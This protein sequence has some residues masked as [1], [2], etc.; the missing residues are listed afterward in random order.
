[1]AEDRTEYD[2]GQCARIIAAI[3]DGNAATGGARQVARGVALLG[4]IRLVTGH[5]LILA[6]ER[7]PLGTVCG[8]A[9]YGVGATELVRVASASPRRNARDA[10]RPP[11]RAAA[12]ANAEERRLK[13]LL[14][15]VDLTGGFFF[16]HTYRLTATLQANAFDPNAALR[17]DFDSMFAWNAHLS[18]PLR[19]ALGEDAA[20]RWLVPLVHGFFSQRVVDLVGRRVRIALVARR[21]RHFAGTRYRR[22]GVNEEGHVA[23]EVETEQIVDD[24]GG[25]G[26]GSRRVPAVS[27]VVQTRGSIPLFWTQELSARV[28]RPEIT[29]QRFDPT[30]A[31]TARHFQRL[32]DR[33]GPPTLVLSLV[34][35]QERRAREGAL[36]GELAAALHRVNSRLPEARERVACVHWDFAKHMTRGGGGGGGGGGVKRGDG[37]SGEA[38]NP[39]NPP[40]EPPPP[41]P[42]PFPS[43]APATTPGLLELTR[44]AAGA[45]ELTG[46]FVVAPVAGLR[47]AEKRRATDGRG[48]PVSRATTAWREARCELF[49]GMD[50]VGDD[51]R[52]APLGGGDPD[53]PAPGAGRSA[54]PWKHAVGVITP[55][56]SSAPNVPRASSVGVARQR[57]VLRSHCIDCLDRTNVAQFA[58]GLAS[59]AAQLEALGIGD[60]APVAPDGTLAGVLMRAYRAMGNALALQ[61]GGSEAHAKVREFRR[62]ERAAR[63]VG[64]EEEGERVA[65]ASF[66]GFGDAAKR[67]GETAAS[68]SARFLAVRAAI[69]FQRRH[70]RGQAGG[71]RPLPGTPRRTASRRTRTRRGRR[72]VVRFD[73]S[74]R[75]PAADRV[76]EL[77]ASERHGRSAR[78]RDGRRV[79]V[80]RRRRVAPPAPVRVDAAEDIAAAVAAAATIASR[81]PSRA[82]FSAPPHRRDPANGLADVSMESME[83]YEAYVAGT[84]L[85]SRAE[86]SLADANDE[87]NAGAAALEYAGL[88]TARAVTLRVGGD[89]RVSEE[90]SAAW[91]VAR[92]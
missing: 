78:R 44:V 25:R 71:H 42:P 64:E 77:A 3:A 36:R 81:R 38:R 50:V 82:V 85:A 55:N 34:R 51:A 4:S 14:S 15:R 16:S 31:A 23:N 30:H 54:N 13:R 84:G 79:D 10:H 67:L 43:P 86:S 68:S 56:A 21:S 61:Y 80:V 20:S 26:F 17:R 41:P 27:S 70:R 89:P 53:A 49:T 24:P 35:S 39:S 76:A 69:L 7:V 8:H 73:A 52:A 83:A 91:E 92:G 47:S 1:M 57:G 74:R 6:K 60:G 46:V 45:L 33:F 75:R 18:H 11:R 66:F 87:W 40:L 19:A 72:T 65:P 59:L 48:G 63:D 88:E 58:F 29:L 28:A 62:D 90:M 37:V 9:V 12:D 2:E 22:R 32:D 5:H